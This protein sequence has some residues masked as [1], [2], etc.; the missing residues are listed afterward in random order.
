MHVR[1]EYEDS[2]SVE[3]ISYD[4]LTNSIF[5]S[6][7]DLSD[8]E[9]GRWEL[10]VKADYRNSENIEIYFERPLFIRVQ[11]NNDPQPASLDSGPTQTD[12]QTELI[13]PSGNEIELVPYVPE[14]DFSVPVVEEVDR[15]GSVTIS[16]P[17]EG[18]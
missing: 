1:I 4:S 14:G 2:E 13:S 16:L 6:R 15:L 7:E 5:V 11:V 9:I 18:E 17:G 8:A 10:T 3:F 12:L